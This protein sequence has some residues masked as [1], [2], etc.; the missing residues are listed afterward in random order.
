MVGTQGSNERESLN[1]RVQPRVGRGS[2][3]EWGAIVKE[4]H[5]HCVLGKDTSGRSMASGTFW[6]TLRSR[7]LQ[8]LLESKDPLPTPKL[9][10]AENVTYSIRS[11]TPEAPPAI[12]GL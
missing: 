9:T 11:F 1:Q 6:T 10:P 7:I 12:P 3:L 4:K 8:R 2:R 5:T